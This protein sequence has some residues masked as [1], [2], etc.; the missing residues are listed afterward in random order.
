[1]SSDTVKAIFRRSLALLLL[2]AL[3]AGA[4]VFS[5]TPSFT[6][7]VRP[8]V[9]QA[10]ASATLASGNNY[11]TTQR[12]TEAGSA[13]F[14]ID[15]WTAGMPFSSAPP[16]FN[17]G[18]IITPPPLA[19]LTKAPSVVT[20]N[21][22]F[23]LAKRR[24]L[25]AAQAG[26]CV[27]D[28]PTT[29]GTTNRIT[30][31]IGA[32]PGSPA[33]R[34][35]WTDNYTAGAVSTN[36]TGLPDNN[37]YAVSL[38][39]VY[40]KIHYNA[41][42]PDF[43]PADSQDTP[44]GQA[45][46]S[47]LAVAQLGLSAVWIDGNSLLRA[48][49]Q[50]GYLIVEYF[51]TPSHDNSAGYEIVY[52]GPARVYQSSVVL[53][54]RLL[55]SEGADVA[56]G[57][58]ASISKA[59]DYVV[60][61]STSGSHFQNNI[62]ATAVNS[63]GTQPTGDPS[64]TQILWQR[65]GN[66]GI[67]WPYEAHWYAITWAGDE[68]AH[69]FVY[70][71]ANPAGSP[72]INIP[73]NYTASIVWSE[74][75]GTVVKTDST[76]STV[77]PVGEGRALLQY[78]NNL[79][80]WFVP[81]RV[82]ARTN[83]AYVSNQEVFWPIGTPLQPVANSPRLQFD[84]VANYLS[85][86]SDL[87]PGFTTELWIKP[88]AVTNYQTLAAFLDYPQQATV[89]A[90]LT[91]AGGQL[92]LGV[93]TGGTVTNDVL[94]TDGDFEAAANNTLYTTNVPGWTV[95]GG[96]V[97]VNPNGTGTFANNGRS[98]NGGNVLALQNGGT[99]SQ[100]IAGLVP[101]ESYTLSFY[102]NART[103]NTPHLRVQADT[104]TLFDRAFT[105]VGGTAAYN[106]ASVN[107]TAANSSALLTFTE[108]NTDSTDNSALVDG[109]RLYR[110]GSAVEL[111]STNSIPAGVWSHVAFTKSPSGQLLLYVNGVPNGSATVGTFNGLS[112]QS[113]TYAEVGVGQGLP[114]N[115][116]AQT[117]LA[118]FAGE[119]R[120]VRLWSA[121]LSGTTIQQ[122]LS[123]ALRGDEPNLDH[124]ITP[125]WQ[126]TSTPLD[127]DGEA[128]YQVLDLATG[129][130]VPG[131]GTPNTAGQLPYSLNQRLTVAGNANYTE[132][133]LTWKRSDAQSVEFWLRAGDG[134][135]AFSSASTPL[136]E[137]KSGTTSTVTLALAGGHLTLATNGILARTATPV[138][139]ENSSHH[140]ALV[141]SG[142]SLLLYLDGVSQGSV[143][144]PGSG[145]DVLATKFVLEAGTA[146]SSTLNAEFSD[147]RIYTASHSTAQVGA[148]MTSAADLTDGSLIR[149]YDFSQITPS[150]VGS[151]AVLLVPDAA[152]GYAATYHGRAVL[153]ST[154]NLVPPAEVTGGIIR[155]G[156]A[157]HP[158][159]YAAESRIIPVNDTP[160]N[161][162]IEVWWSSSFTAP[163]L[164]QPLGIPGIVTRYRLMDPVAAPVLVV[165]GQ[166]TAG[167]NLPTTWSQPS[168]Y[169]QNDVTAVGYNPNEEHALIF[170][171]AAYALRWDLN[172]P[173]TSPGYMLLQYKDTT[174]GSLSY[175]QP[176]QVIPTNSVYPNFD[177]ALQ[178]GNEV[179][180]PTP[181]IYLLP[182][183]PL[184][185]PGTDDPLHRLFQDRTGTY[186]AQSASSGTPD[187][188]PMRWQYPLE[189]GFYWPTS[190]GTKNPGDSVPFGNTSNGLTVHYTISWPASVPTLAL[191]QTLSTAINGL[192]AIY[193]QKS[194][195][196]L[197][198]E[199]NYS[200]KTSAYIVD[201]TTV[202]SSSLPST[203]GIATATDTE[204]GQVYF[205]LL[206][207][208]LRDRVTWDPTAKKLN[209]TGAV[210]QPITGDSYVLP[211]WLGSA[212]DANSDYSILAGLS[213]NI[214][215]RTAV[216]GLRQPANVIPN[217]EVPFSS[218]VLTPSGFAGGHVTLGFNT[219]TNFNLTGDP[220][221]VV[222]IF[223]DT[224]RLY[225][226]SVIVL[227]SDN[228]FDQYTTLRHNGDFGG[229][230]SQY[231]FEWRYSPSNYGQVPASP[232]SNLAAWL[233]Y[234]ATT[235]GL[236]RIVFGGPGLLTLEDVY[237]SCHWRC[238]AAGAPNTNWSSWTD[239][240]LVEN[241]LTRALD[242]INPFDQ[243]VGSL[244]NNH[245]D[246][247][248]SILSQA[249]K[250]YVGAVPLNMDNADDF[251]LIETYET[252]LQQARNLSIDAGYKDDNVNASL[253]DAASKLNELYTMLG[254]EALSD[255]KDPTIAW[256]SRDLNDVYFGSRASSLFAFQGI[257][258][259]LLEEELGLLRGLDD[260]T[261]TPVTTYPV[262]NRLY[263]NFTKGINSG[264]PAYALNYNI[265]SVTSNANGSITEADAAKLYPQ[266]HGDAYGHYLTALMEYYR[267]LENTNFT[268]YPRAEVKTIGG[269]N[270]TFDYV[271]ERKMAASALQLARTSVEIIDRTFRRDYQ[272]DPGKRIPLYQDGNTNRAWSAT[273]WSDRA[274][275]G[276][277]YNWIVLNSLLPAALD[278]AGSVT[279]VTRGTVP[280]L[281]Q[282][283]GLMGTIQ[284]K[285]DDIDRG[286][287]PMGVA[288]NVVPFD[289]DPLLADAGKSHFEQIYDR[290]VTAMQAA[291]TVLQRASEA[292]ENLRRQ[293]VSLE[294]FRYQIAQRENEFNAQ[295]VDLYGSPYPDD[296][297]PTGAFVTGYQGPDLYHYNYID[298]D[299]FSPADAGAVTNVTF[300]SKYSITGDNLDTLTAVGAN[301]TYS[302]N[303]DGIPVLPD[304][305]TGGQRAIYGKIEGALGDYIRTWIS[306]RSAIAHQQDHKN[307][308]AARLQRLQD[309][310]SYSDYYGAIDSN[311]ANQQSVVNLVKEGI[312]LSLSTL[313]TLDAEV[314]SAYEA[315]KDPL[316]QSFIAGLADGGDL[317]FPARIGLAITKLVGE[318]SIGAA[319]D[320][321]NFAS[322]AAD[323]LSGQLDNQIAANADALAGAEEQSQT[324]METTILLSQVNAD[325]D[326]VYGA[327]VALRQ[328][329][330]NYL[331]L[332]GKG[333]RL[334]EDLLAFRQANAARIQEAR[335]ADVIF[336]TFKNEDLEEYLNA[337]QQASRYVFAAARV[338]DYETGLLDPTVVSGQS[339][340][341]MGDTMKATQLGDMVNGQPVGGSANAG[342]LASIL[343][344]M[345]ANWG[346]LK[347]RFGINNPTR[348]K[349]RISLRQELF[350]IGKSADPIT[351]TNNL[352]VWQN[353]LYTYRVADLRQV[354]EFKNFCQYYSPM[355]TNEPALVI[356]FSTQIKAGLNIFGLPLVGGDTVFDSAHFTTKVR[357]SA[358]SF[359]GY[360]QNVGSQLTKSP[361]VYLVPA[362]VDR[363]RTPISGGATIRDWQ[364]IDQVWPIPYPSAAGNVGFPLESVGTDNVHIIR[365]FPPMRAYD[366]DQLTA[367]G[368][369]PY[370]SRLI[371]RSVW[372]TEWVLIIPGSALSGS[373]STALDSL[374]EGISDI[375]LLL[376][377]Y[378]YSGT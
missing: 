116:A 337:F 339:G 11:P 88:S 295:L 338:Y 195:A 189:S 311:L 145:S 326:S 362:G 3:P 71:P 48:R 100:T 102:Y 151:E 247:T 142:G 209:L 166:K 74:K 160:T 46:R 361:R 161:S 250:R 150:T 132:V 152:R 47:A 174:R 99:I 342:D 77:Q 315:S 356:P 329:W 373:P 319:K 137:A 219:R 188:V 248:T 121:L 149:W 27:I 164:D 346:V 173:A 144:L 199:A 363:Q 293:E 332:V 169:Y 224:T 111:T 353:R 56:A 80:V 43:D 324:V 284:D 336:R 16:D 185:G 206:P 13:R 50:S 235:R 1:M 124:L 313:D 123:V 90:A 290:A 26:T 22:A 83:G 73:T 200:G 42:I 368:S 84:G 28:W 196:I 345:N 122:N 63:D 302:V 215:W 155:S 364:V 175:L 308:L 126:Q 228:K 194:A 371:A 147:F 17:F 168:V 6:N 350:R 140:I 97:A 343:A 223:V 265:P 170:G 41:V 282:L 307:Q 107:F 35:F 252:L 156:T 310:N 14:K 232:N 210:V 257:V 203:N 40:A 246:L 72:A 213:S 128:G 103:G 327:A 76:T 230:P 70:D 317:S 221:S 258:P 129:E 125:L 369:V 181:I 352:G 19:D 110:T 177:G 225:T 131:Y 61:W 272:L 106:V 263:W 305:W 57:L 143:T 254:D 183:S 334:Q 139:D 244:A 105:A 237:F 249:G 261:S 256:G 44:A 270:V 23:Y 245:L 287:S 214:S 29:T 279:N 5:T 187:S 75:G 117:T 278:G 12:P 212:S 85:F 271:D 192:P 375:Y 298:R 376:D 220:V 325:T 186:W 341:F 176:V 7:P 104:A 349:H 98:Q 182:Y 253:L 377:T 24:Q 67:V 33:S 114:I 236:S 89:Q 127:P 358:V 60:Q 301:V 136:L 94:I 217:A 357:G 130:T 153:G 52:V 109:I 335:Y 193:G 10:S 328:A 274:S 53:G 115:G 286:D 154:I 8:G 21:G 198:D 34:L 366:D 275:Q 64:K 222:P 120:E 148:D 304:S 4:D 207:P 69:L 314:A 157:Y 277:L 81:V 31:S 316:P 172:Q 218:I 45:A 30:Y 242:G 318:E 340:D 300:N 38:S 288:A 82:A 243:R 312:D 95:A 59:K 273:E 171:P 62:F 180:P 204:L 285:Q 32:L 348:E 283:A 231:E 322:Y 320:A 267:L 36:A 134:N 331:T 96:G 133:P 37:E 162:L 66:L 197:F 51:D 280:E 269:V 141:A 191:G 190:L 268:W 260:T 205:T 372:N 165:A 370:D 25:V 101:G 299:L 276:T 344:K 378:S 201:P 239:P 251:G 240:V 78:Q 55:P 281:S 259:T 367:A 202:S 238:V 291:Y 79:D 15:S 113:A 2:A 54:D 159:I 58:I 86:S 321:A 39:H 229:D 309:H 108:Y 179:Q 9:G 65:T 330:Q 93:F 294:T 216:A 227:Y 68:S 292:G 112:P 184:S 359:A 87:Q 347:G 354:P 233:P 163:Y 167:F 264:E 306:L 351:E 146:A 297:G 92:R 333:I 91:L 374:I 241:W 20:T 158:G 255:A 211:A 289:L 262:Y 18:D 49:N 119:I 208:H 323:K 135:L 226:G 303:S 296:I 178:V 355:G 234:G 365:R 360:S 266:G 118:P 138:L